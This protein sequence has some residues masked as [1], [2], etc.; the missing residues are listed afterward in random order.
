MMII[1]IV[2]LKLWH[3]LRIDE[4]WGFIGHIALKWCCLSRIARS[5]TPAK[6]LIVVLAISSKSP[7]ILVVL[8]SSG[9]KTSKNFVP[10]NKPLI[11]PIFALIGR[12]S[13]DKAYL[14]NYI[15]TKIKTSKIISIITIASSKTSK[16]S[17]RIVIFLSSKIIL[18]MI[19]TFLS[20]ISSHIMH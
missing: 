19:L 7:K 3:L 4:A 8:T 15:S 14:T 13:R 20:K 5:K 17:T 2:C 9:P 18:V 1:A 6:T 12:V 10:W 16:I 11:K